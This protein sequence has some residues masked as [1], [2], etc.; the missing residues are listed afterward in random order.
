MAGRSYHVS[1]LRIA[2]RFTCIV[3]LV[4]VHARRAQTRSPDPT[5]LITDHLG[6]PR[7]ATSPTLAPAC[8]FVC[9]DGQ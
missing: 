8:L 9:P 4:S 1:S 5:G 7:K 2:D 3:L 6:G